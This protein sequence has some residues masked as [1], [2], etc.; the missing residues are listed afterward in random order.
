M[1]IS[2]EEKKKSTNNLVKLGL[3]GEFEGRRMVF[4]RLYRSVGV[5]AKRYIFITQLSISN[6]FVPVFESETVRKSARGTYDFKIIEILATTLVRDDLN[7]LI[8]IELFE[9]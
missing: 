4:A 2:G 1:T 8:K 9:W 5:D 7:R 3:I 6:R